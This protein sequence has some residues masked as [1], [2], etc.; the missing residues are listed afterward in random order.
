MF[1]SY[2]NRMAHIGVN[3]SEMHRMQ[4]NMVIEQTWDRDP[5]YR[6]V[7]VVKVDSGLPEVTEHHELIDAK[8]NVDTYQKVDSNEPAYYL[9][10]RHG[11]E[12]LNPDIGIGSYVYMADEDGEWK[13]WLITTFD[14][15]PQFRQY[16]I[17]ECNW[18]LGWVANG[19]IYY[20]LG[21]LRE[22]SSGDV[23]E[24]SRTSVVDGTLMIWLPT[25]A[26]SA[27]IGYN[28]RFLISDKR[29]AT[30]LAWETS[31]IVDTSPFGLTKVKMKQIT[32]D[33]VHD[34]AELMLANYHD[35]VIAP[36]ESGK[37]ISTSQF[38]ITHNGAKAAV[39]IGGSEKVFTAQLSPDNYFDVLWSVSDGIKTYDCGYENNA[40][41]FGD[42][43]IV[44]ADRTMRL[45]I[46][47]NYDL[48]GTILTI[49]AKCADGSAGELKV[50]V[51]G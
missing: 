15:R 20:H 38:V 27:T 48:V 9:Q 40:W 11:A 34:S 8:F 37:E 46:A 14:E 7:Y 43:T 12:K 26:D 24:N 23:D 32:F 6:K 10:F 13:W 2:K 17:N 30:P 41:T 25:T 39:K 51:V 28:Q 47:S 18:K 4:S 21:V 31:R 42:Y 50:E 22:G 45:K 29:R 3:A 5:N 35:D 44:T 1:E 49:T 33:P 16:T 36:V 19:K